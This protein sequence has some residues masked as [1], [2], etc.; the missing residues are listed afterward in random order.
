MAARVTSEGARAPSAP[1]AGPDGPG[2]D[3][4]PAPRADAAGAPVAGAG[5]ESASARAVRRS[6]APTFFAA[7]FWRRGAG[8]AVDAAIVSPIA[9]LLW[10]VASGVAGVA[11]PP[12]RHRGLDFWLDLALTQDPALWGAIGLAAAIGVIYLFLFHVTLARTP[13][14]RL[15]HMRIIDLY[16]DPPSI[17]RSAIRTLGYLACVATLGLGFLWIGFDRERRGLH[18]WLSG[19]YV[20]LD[21]N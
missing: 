12:T 4:A 20:V 21:R 19:T 15:L 6:R 9:A 10:W 18:D 2:A 5:P 1:P 16:G 3:A 8:A 13:G 17:A 7:G 14:M 11:L